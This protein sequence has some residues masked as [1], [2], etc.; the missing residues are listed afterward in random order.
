MGEKKWKK[1]TLG[2]HAGFRFD[3]ATGAK[4]VPVYQTSSFVFKNTAHA[5]D[6]F[7]LKETGNVY[8]RLMNPTTDVLEKRVAALEPVSYTHLT[9]PTKR[10]V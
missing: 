10:I 6:L 5:A 9:L 1:P 8:T 2:L 7:A 4:A 3:P